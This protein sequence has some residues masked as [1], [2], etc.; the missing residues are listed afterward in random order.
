MSDFSDFINLVYAIEDRALLEDFLVG[1]TTP[2][3]RMDFAKRV[4]IVRMLI[5]GKPQM[6]IAQELN[7]AIATVTRGSKE[8]SE[9]RFKILRQMQQQ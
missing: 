8:L 3:E 7:V 4:D 1:I 2:A 5:E 6:Q 9:G